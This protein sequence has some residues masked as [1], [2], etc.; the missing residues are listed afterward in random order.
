MFRDK[1]KL[2][3][4]YLTELTKLG[5]LFD[6][7]KLN[8]CLMGGYA[9]LAHGVRTPQHSDPIIV[10]NTEDK[11]KMLKMLFKLNYTILNISENKIQIKKLCKAGDLIFDIVLGNVE[12]KNFVVDF[13]SR[14]LILSP[15]M[16]KQDRKEVWGYFRKGRGGKGYFRAAPVEE[17]YFSKM[18]S[19][20]DY[21]IND[22][23]IIKGS[24]KL[25]FDRLLK[26]FKK[27]GLV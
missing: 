12:G 24:G 15:T 5:N 11:L 13:G 20:K 18:N 9:L 10:A 8:Y 16:F 26:L 2:E 27:N 7:I 21:D 19:D 23:D 14:K 22:L 17:V 25:D 1:L 6:T 3:R 4:E